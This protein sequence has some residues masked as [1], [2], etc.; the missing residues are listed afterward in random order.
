MKT[1]RTTTV[2]AGA[3]L[4][5]AL[6]TAPAM[7]TAVTWNLGSDSDTGVA[8]TANTCSNCASSSIGYGSATFLSGSSSGNIPLILSA[9][10]SATVYHNNNPSNGVTGYANDGTSATD[11]TKSSSG[12]GVT[13]TGNSGS[14]SN[15]IQTNEAILVNAQALSSAGYTLTSLTVGSLQSGEGFTIY[16]LTTQ[17]YNNFTSAMS[18]TSATTVN[19]SSPYLPT[20][21][22]PTG[23][24]EENGQSYTSYGASSISVNLGDPSDPYYLVEVSQYQCNS[25][26][27]ALVTTLTATQNQNNPPPVPEPASMTLMAVGLAG[28][29]ALRRRRRTP[30]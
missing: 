22:L 24:S 2:L 18:G 4:F 29:T 28:L 17:A 27:D 16:G 15:Q 14:V 10:S 8:G 13:Y 21:S 3:M 7:A 6:M 25:D 12:V 1:L 26:T 23:W 19:A 9:Y 5:G 11:L 20:G 30:A